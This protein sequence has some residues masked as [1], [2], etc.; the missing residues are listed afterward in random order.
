[1]ANSHARGNVETAANL[2]E[3]F[4][5]G[6]LDAATAGWDADIELRE[7]EGIVGGGTF[8]G[9]DEIIE[10]LFAGLAN[11]WTDVSVVPERFVDGGDTVVALITWSGTSSETGRSVEFRGAH[12]FDFEDGKIVRWTSYADTALFN[13]AAG[14]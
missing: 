6:D 7:P 4:A 1:M 9:R 14:Q 8:R 12:V 2:Y 11:D 5:E 3:S 13:A 10:N